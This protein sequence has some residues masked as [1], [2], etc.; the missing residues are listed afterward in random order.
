MSAS[1]AEE[2]DVRIAIAVR[3][4]SQSLSWIG[5]QAGIFER[6]GLNVTFPAMET[7]A[8]EAVAG[9][10]RGE[11][12]FV[13]VG[14]APILGYSGFGRGAL[15]SVGRFDAH[16]KDGRNLFQPRLRNG[17]LPGNQAWPVAQSS[18]K[19]EHENCGANK[20]ENHG[21][22]VCKAKNS[23]CR[24]E[25]STEHGKHWVGGYSIRMREEDC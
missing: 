21:K 13:E 24:L 12:Y 7:A 17:G 2:R 4:T 11:W 15:P 20:R 18:L 3:T 5:T 25:F 22:A 1:T 9:L 6:H 19:A 10:L 16:P 14:G 8:V 23:A